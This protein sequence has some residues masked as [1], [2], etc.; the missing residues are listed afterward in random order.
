MKHLIPINLGYLI[1]IFLNVVFSA[2][3]KSLYWERIDVEINL[4]RDGS[5]DITEVQE[6]V[7]DGDWNGGW[8]KLIIRGCDEIIFQTLEEKNDKK[9]RYEP[10][11][12]AHKYKYNLRKSGEVL[13]I[14]WRSRLPSEPVYKNTHKTFVLCYR[15]LGAIQPHKN[16]DE[17]YWKAIFEERSGLI[18]YATA[19]V[20]FPQ[21]VKVEPGKF[22]VTF[23]TRAANARWEIRPDNTIFFKADNLSPREKFE[24]KIEFPKGITA[25]KYDPRRYFKQTLFPALPVLTAVFSLPL[26]LAIMTGLYKRFGRDF[27]FMGNLGYFR[28]PP[29]QLPPAIAGTLVD[30]YVDI[31]EVVATIFDLARRGFLEIIEQESGKWLFKKRDYILRL[32]KQPKQDEISEYEREILESIFGISL[33]EGRKVKLSTLQNKFYNDLPTIKQK[34]YHDAVRR[35]FFV[36]DPRKI[37]NKYYILGVTLIVIGSFLTFLNVP[38]AIILI[39]G[40]ILLSTVPFTFLIKHLR[41]NPRALIT[42]RLLFSFFFSLLFLLF[43]VVMTLI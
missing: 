26:A 3:A 24:V 19:T 36:V 22:F 34:I 17:L 27:E 11:N 8:R 15:V 18:R 37:R 25:V 4:Q 30:E 38:Q 40:G 7:F 14:K 33:T 2:Q 28:S 16:F 5:L 10:G 13:E 21:D 12:I 23:Y 9:I 6:Y 29:S 1:L 42:G 20:R 41:Y 32:I 43:T 31:R 39:C 35:G